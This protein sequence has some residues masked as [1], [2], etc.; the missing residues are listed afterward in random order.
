MEHKLRAKDVINIAAPHTWPGSVVP[1][2]VGLAISYTLT[3]HIDLVMALCLYVIVIMMQSAVNTFDDYADYVKGTDTLGNSPNA[4]DAVIVYGLKPGTALVLGFLFLA[5][6][7]IPAVYV[8]MVCG[9]VPLV[10]GMI[11][12][13]VLMWYA[14]GKYPLSYLPL[15]ELFCGIVMG[16]LIPL[17][18]V[19]MQTGQ[20][21][22]FVLVQA[23]PPIMGMAVNMFSNNGCDIDRDI[24]AGR[25]TLAC[26]LGLKRT[27]WLYR[28]ML[29]VWVLSPA[30]IL[31][32]QLCWTAVVVY[33]FECLAFSHLVLRQYRHQLGP[34]A[35][36]AV[37][38]GATTLV[39]MVGFAYSI[40]MLVGM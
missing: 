12:A 27:S 32:A 31:A 18:A 1:A 8:V 14:F 6:A 38:T 2:T 28:I 16:G 10:I 23:I 24:P 33:V 22:W 20:L 21:H 9:I 3:G 13:V 40:A 19:Y 30:V 26:L 29:I 35:R 34:A 4:Y 39:T 5:I 37:M 25:K 17:V 36:E 7:L 15:G 11:G